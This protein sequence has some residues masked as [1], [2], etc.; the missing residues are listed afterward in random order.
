MCS[1]NS[2]GKIYVS[3]PA[4][5]FFPS[6]GGAIEEN[7]ILIWEIE[8]TGI[9][10]W[11]SVSG[12]THPHTPTLTHTHLLCEN[13]SNTST[14]VFPSNDDVTD[15]F[16]KCIS[17]VY[18]LYSM[19]HPHFTSLHHLT[20]RC[21]VRV[22]LRYYVLFYVM[23][24]HNNREFSSTSERKSIAVVSEMRVTW[25]W[26]VSTRVTVTVVLEALFHRSGIEGKS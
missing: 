8:A 23:K 10:S 6:K 13:T 14:N 9:R 17:L 5:C 1:E 25:C 22:K 11:K 15:K 2:D 19:F 24:G 4:S 16:A 12:D 21:Y 26:R 20:R 18:Y 7:I 3:F